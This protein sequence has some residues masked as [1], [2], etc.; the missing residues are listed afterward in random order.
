MNFKHLTIVILTSV[1]LFVSACDRQT[2]NTG[3]EVQDAKLGEAEVT[4]DTVFISGKILTVDQN[5]SIAQALA[6]SGDRIVA[7]GSNA[8]VDDLINEDTRVIDLQGKTVIPGLIDNHMHFIRMPQRWNLQARI[9]GINS[10][11][12]A[13]DA[14]AEKASSMEPGEWLMVQGGWSEGQFA[15]QAGGFTLEELDAVVPDNPLFLQIL[16]SHAYA[17]SLALAAV[18]IDPS[19]GS[20]HGPPLIVAEPPYGLLNEQMPTVNAAQLEQNVLDVISELNKAGLTSVYDVG[21]PPEGDITLLDRMSENGPLNLRVWHTLKYQAY[22]PE[23]I[24]VT[25]ELINSN[26]AN[27]TDD[28]LGLLGV[29][30]HV[31]LPM[32]DLPNVTEPY[33]DDVVAEFKQIATA[34]AQ[35]GYR[36]NEHSM[37]D[38]TI[39]SIL[40]AYEEINQQTPLAPLRWSL[41]HVLTISEESIQRAKDLGLTLAVH[42]V[43]MNMPPFL[44][45]PIRKIQDSGIVW[46]LGTDA[47]I[48]A[49][50]QPFITLGWVVSGQS[51]NGNTI[52]EEPVTRE[53][54]LIAHTRSNAYLLHK[55]DDLGTLEVGKFADLV[56]LDKDYMTVPVEEIFYIEPQMTMVGGRIVFDAS[57]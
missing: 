52:I 24:P 29:G 45:P 40:G 17:N 31:Y 18:G 50:Y 26:T 13:L 55:D 16:Y 9:D 22:G 42:S 2:E 27:S 46:G 48:V 10:R 25:V 41:E 5:F 35:S 56:V 6:V 53:E 15:D 32:F 43:A 39:Q 23:D 1:G 47:S 37:M 38:I 7:V 14:L 36:I 44:Q 33:S 19:E 54:A 49:A 4:A 51:I 57:L 8:S 21:R 28:Y 11:Q 34:A 20:R 3:I 30:E 12:A